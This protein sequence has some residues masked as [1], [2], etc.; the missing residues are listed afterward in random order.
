MNNHLSL[1]VLKTCKTLEELEFLTLELPV[2]YEELFCTY[3][4]FPPPSDVCAETDCAGHDHD[5]ISFTVY[6]RVGG[7]ASADDEVENENKAVL[8]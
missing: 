4:E 5:D 3:S 2:E 6:S 1:Q 7:S 8:A